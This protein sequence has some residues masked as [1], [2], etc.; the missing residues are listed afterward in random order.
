MYRSTNA[1]RGVIEAMLRHEDEMSWKQAWHTPAHHGM[2]SPSDVMWPPHKGS[3][4]PGKD[5]G[6]E[7]E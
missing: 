7:M 6:P 1:L 2:W 5:P 4:Y 3:A